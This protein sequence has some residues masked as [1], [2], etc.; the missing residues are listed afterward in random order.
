MCTSPASPPR[1]GCLFGTRQALT[2][3]QGEKSD[4][5]AGGL[6][7][8]SDRPAAQ[9]QVLNYLFISDFTAEGKALLRSGEFQIQF[10]QKGASK[11]P[12]TD[13]FS[14]SLST[15]PVAP[16]PGQAVGLEGEEVSLPPLLGGVG[17]GAGTRSGTRGWMPGQQQGVGGAGKGAS[18]TLV[19]P[20]LR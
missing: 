5:K 13:L 17:V 1:P 11:A 6:D 10:P 18:L 7:P 19:P 12:V 16:T 8:Y 20:S 15:C 2:S 14:P 3:Q 4:P 9:M